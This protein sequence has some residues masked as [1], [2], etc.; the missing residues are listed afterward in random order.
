MAA[1]PSDKKDVEQVEQ[2]NHSGDDDMSRQD[3][4]NLEYDAALKEQDRWLP[5]A[6]GVCNIL[7]VRSPLLRDLMYSSLPLPSRLSNV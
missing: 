1:S 4:G 7:S 3:E 2:G 6:N 5:I